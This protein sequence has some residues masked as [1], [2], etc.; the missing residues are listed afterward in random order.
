MTWDCSIHMVFM[1]LRRLFSTWY[2][3]EA[4]YFVRPLKNN[5]TTFQFVP[6]A[7]QSSQLHEHQAFGTG[8]EISYAELK[9][10]EQVRS[11]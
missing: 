4:S 8:V 7:E 5:T 11:C 9:A 2:K 10:C 1:Q 6:C 3:I